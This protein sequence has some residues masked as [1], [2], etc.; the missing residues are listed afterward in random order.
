M[1]PG[2]G[3]PDAVTVCWILVDGADG[4]LSRIRH[5]LH[6]LDLVTEDDF[7]DLRAGRAHG[8][9]CAKHF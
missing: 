8:P 1:S 9:A 3:D 5:L 7:D 2:D 4:K 6:P